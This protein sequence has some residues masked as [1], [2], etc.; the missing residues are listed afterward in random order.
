VALFRLGEALEAQQQFGAAKRF[1]S[2]AARSVRASGGDGGGGDAAAVYAE[3]AAAAIARR[4][5]HCE[6]QKALYTPMA[7]DDEED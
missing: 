6:Y 2:K 7:A 5:Q 4:V 1:M 3:D